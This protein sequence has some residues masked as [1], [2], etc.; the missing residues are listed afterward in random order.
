[1]FIRVDD[2]YVIQIRMNKQQKE[3]LKQ[4]LKKAY[5]NHPVYRTPLC[6][7]PLYQERDVMEAVEK[8][9]RKK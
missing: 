2:D 8:W 7:S 5:K 1:M 3:S 6:G 4:E 9:L